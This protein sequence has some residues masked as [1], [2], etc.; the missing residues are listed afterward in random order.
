MQTDL[1]APF[2]WAV[3]LEEGKGVDGVGRRFADR[4]GAPPCRTPARAAASWGRVTL[5]SS[6][7]AVPHSSLLRTNAC[8]RD[9]VSLRIVE[10]HAPAGSLRE[11]EV[12]FADAEPCKQ[13]ST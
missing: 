10:D 4:E 8:R 6:A 9:S 5:A 3:E 11:D 13:H 7:G 12:H 2:A 1:F